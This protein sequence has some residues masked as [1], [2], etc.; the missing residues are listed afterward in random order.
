MSRDLKVQEESLASNLRRR[1]SY[2]E[3]LRGLRVRRVSRYLVRREIVWKPKN[4]EI[5]ICTIGRVLKKKTW[6][7]PVLISVPD[8]KKKVLRISLNYLASVIVG[9]HIKSV[10]STNC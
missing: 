3:H 8:A 4:R 5:C 10:S 9:V 2:I 7:F 1:S 6:D